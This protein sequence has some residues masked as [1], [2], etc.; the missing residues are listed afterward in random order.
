M[1]FLDK[2]G[3]IKLPIIYDEFGRFLLDYLLVKLNG[4]WGAVNGNLDPLIPPIYEEMEE[5]YKRRAIVKKDNLY[6]VIDQLGNTII[7][8]QFLEIK[9]IFC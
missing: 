6:G 7:P 8:I 1:G 9:S 2:E 4:K 3:T 5:H